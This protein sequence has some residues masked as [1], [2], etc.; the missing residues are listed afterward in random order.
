VI[1]EDLKAVM[2]Y[3]ALLPFPLL[4]ASFSPKVNQEGNPSF[5]LSQTSHLVCPGWP[6]R[7]ILEL[8]KDIFILNGDTEGFKRIGA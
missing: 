6:T 4:P 7:G 8:Q 2:L 5:R 1:N 3:K